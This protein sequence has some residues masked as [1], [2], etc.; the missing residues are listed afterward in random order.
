VYIKSVESAGTITE[1]GETHVI[2]AFTGGND[3]GE[4]RAVTGYTGELDNG[5]ERG[6]TDRDGPLASRHPV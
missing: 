1:V 2:R 5:T 6:V 4:L 3:P